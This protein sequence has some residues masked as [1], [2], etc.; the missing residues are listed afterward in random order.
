MRRPWINSLWLLA[1]ALG[2]HFPALALNCPQAQIAGD[3]AIKEGIGA[4]WDENQAKWYLDYFSSAKPDE[5]SLK[6]FTFLQALYENNLLTCYYGWP[7]AEG[8]STQWMTVRLKTTQTVVPE[9]Q[10]TLC[11]NF[12][13]ENCQFDLS[14]PVTPEPSAAPSTTPDATTPTTPATPGGTETKPT[15]PTTTPSVP[16]STTTPTTPATPSGSTPSAPGATPPADKS[17]DSKPLEM[18]KL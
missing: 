11:Q 5:N 4:Q 8:T 14:G 6:K 15:T 12:M 7:G 10:G 13:A 3:K 16:G 18:P 1:F 2:A 9:W 17:G